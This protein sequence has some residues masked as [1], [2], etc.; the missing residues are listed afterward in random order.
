MKGFG[1]IEPEDGKDVFVHQTA[2]DAAGISGLDEGDELEFEI[3]KTP[4][5]MQATKLKKL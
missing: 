5:G 3:E 4:K 1:F 2:L